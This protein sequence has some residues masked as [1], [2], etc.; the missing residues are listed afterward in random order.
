MGGP[1]G[2]RV[3][4]RIRIQEVLIFPV[5]VLVLY[6]TTGDLYMS[7]ISPAVVAF[8]FLSFVIFDVTNRD[9]RCVKLGV[10]VSGIAGG[11]LMFLSTDIPSWFGLVVAFVSLLLTADTLVD[12]SN[13]P[14]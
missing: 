3:A 7:V 2:R 14:G 12:L 1:V 4:E 11:A 5:I 13:V 9:V 6:V 10:F 8:V